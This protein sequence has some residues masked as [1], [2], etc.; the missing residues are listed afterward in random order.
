MRY[1]TQNLYFHKWANTSS[2]IQYDGCNVSLGFSFLTVHVV[3]L[4]HSKGRRST[5]VTTS[6]LTT[7]VISRVIMPAYVC[8][9]LNDMFCISLPLEGSFTV[10]YTVTLTGVLICKRAQDK[11]MCHSQPHGIPFSHA[12]GQEVRSSRVMTVS[13]TTQVE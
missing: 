12:R 3:W 2:Y 11:C 6:H 5:S 9:C 7:S 10:R 13:G 1:C 8:M 4:Q